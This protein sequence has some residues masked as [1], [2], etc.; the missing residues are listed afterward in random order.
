MPAGWKKFRIAD[1]HSQGRHFAFSDI[2]GCVA[3]AA[4]NDNFD[5]LCPVPRKSVINSLVTTLL[6]VVA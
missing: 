4:L 1:M 3:E 5:I 2:R 6:R